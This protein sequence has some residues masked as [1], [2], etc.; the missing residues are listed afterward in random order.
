MNIKYPFT[1]KFSNHVYNIDDNTLIKCLS[2]PSIYIQ[3]NEVLQL[4]TVYKTF[5]D[6]VNYLHLIN[7][8]ISLYNFMYIEIRLR[9]TNTLQ[10]TK[11][12]KSLIKKTTR[13]INSY[14]TSPT[15]NITDIL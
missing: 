1:K 3:A 9:E 2:D 4:L 7:S 10:I 12:K 6:I 11:G 13:N 14:N 5:K 8:N 15:N